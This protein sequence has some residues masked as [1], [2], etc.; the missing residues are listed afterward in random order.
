MA[1]VLQGGAELV[2]QGVTSGVRRKHLAV[3]L[4]AGAQVLVVFDATGFAVVLQDR[5]IVAEW[6]AAH[7][8]RIPTARRAHNEMTDHL[9]KILIAMEG[10]RDRTAV[11]TP[12][13]D[14][15]QPAPGKL[16]AAG[17]PCRHLW[18]RGR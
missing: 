4:L 15:D 11:G 6:I 14:G 12:T 2:V 16:P 8:V 18:R 1:D 3:V 5:A 17:R 10:K 13:R 7:H 9:G